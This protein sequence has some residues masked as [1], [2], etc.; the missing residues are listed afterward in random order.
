[1]MR[2]VRAILPLCALLLSL[3]AACGG[4]G[5]P[6]APGPAHQPA[7]ATATPPATV[8]ATA[9]PSPTASPRPEPTATA[10]P[11]PTPTVTPTAT[12]EPTPE[13]PAIEY[14]PLTMGEPR[15][16]PAGTALYFRSYMSCESS[17]DWH[18]AI[19]TETGD[20]LWEHS[21]T[22]LPHGHADLG[23]VS[24]SGQTLA[25]VMCERGVCMSLN[26]ESEDAINALWVSRDGGEAWERW[27]EIPGSYRV[28]SAV[29]EDDVAVELDW[30]EHR[31]W[32]FR[33]G[34]DL[35]PPEDLASARIWGWRAGEDRPDPLWSDTEGTVLVS[36]SGE[37]LPI[38]QD[39]W[40]AAVPPDNSILWNKVEYRSQA[41]GRDL[42]LWMSNRDAVLGA[43]SWDG[44][45]SLVVIDH[46]DGPLFLGFLGT[47][48]C[49]DLVRTVLV[50][51][52]THT[53][54]TIPG[55]DARSHF[56]PLFTRPAP[57]PNEAAQ[58]AIEYT[59]LTWG[60]PRE[61]PAGTALFYGRHSCDGVWDM[62]KA[63][64]GSGVDAWLVERPWGFFDQEDF[65]LQS[66]GVGPDG[67]RLAVLACERGDCES[68]YSPTSE[69]AIL[70]LWSSGDG[71]ST[72]ERWGEVPLESWIS[73]VAGDDVALIESRFTDEPYEYWWFRSGAD[74]T[75][76]EGL[77]SAY[78]AA[79]RRS[80]DGFTPVWASPFPGT[81][82][83]LTPSG[84]RLTVP[85][86]P[87]FTLQDG[88]LLW[89]GV[90]WVRNTGER[91]LFAHTDEQDAV[92]ARYSWDGP[93]PLEL[94]DHLGGELFVGL[95]GGGSCG[96]DGATVLVD[97]ETQ[98]IRPI[99]GVQPGDAI[100]ATQ[101]PRGFLLLLE[102]ARPAPD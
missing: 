37:R 60:E 12:P 75:R 8:V 14:T 65:H 59:P 72:W 1:M 40:I 86:G 77:D 79:W 10:T 100:R 19:A 95:L 84:E 92:V 6:P 85:R 20:L 87:T 21:L 68:S 91:D 82:S 96:E 74:I 25:A 99:T 52:S 43:H 97:F 54:H 9:T 50:D 80:G 26:G 61:L 49:G 58:P 71:G 3:A 42:F 56:I 81:W 35:P 93:E 101:W 70:A 63:V 67:E 15:A 76:P 88:S 33:S 73:V 89:S 27:G 24:A 5:D 62:Y 32:W 7:T 34:Q 13:Q 23:G 98:R 66:F 17:Q 18:R 16:L 41:E 47:H 46:L 69:D 83:Y 39:F 45:T 78:I 94:V 57:S 31:T 48:A 64:A 22:E 28:I 44:P 102:A 53:I 30:P 36:A 90:E 51:F 11:S 2:Q 38:P 55:L 29:A 4:E